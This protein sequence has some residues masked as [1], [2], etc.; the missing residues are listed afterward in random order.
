[1]D[2]LTFLFAVLFTVLMF[3]LVH[4]FIGL[5]LSGVP[6]AANLPEFGEA[7]SIE[8]KTSSSGQAED[9]DGQQPRE[10]FPTKQTAET[11][12]YTGRSLPFS[13]MGARNDRSASQVKVFTDFSSDHDKT[14]VKE[15]S[16]KNQG[17]EGYPIRESVVPFPAR[18]LASLQQSDPK[19]QRDPSHGPVADHPAPDGEKTL[20]EEKHID[21][22][23]T[24][25]GTPPSSVDGNQ[26][27][28][29]LAD[30]GISSN[31][32][33]R[34]SVISGEAM[35]GRGKLACEVSSLGARTDTELS[36]PIHEGEIRNG[37]HEQNLMGARKDRSAS[38]VKV[39]T[40]FSS[41]HDK[42]S[43]KEISG[44]NQGT[45]GYPIK[46]SVV[47]F[48]AR[49]LASLQQS[50]PKIQRDP[51]HGP[52]ADH[53][54]PD[55][56]KTLDE[57]KHIDVHPTRHGTPPSSVDGNQGP[58]SLA[59]SGISS[60][61]SVR[62][63]VISGEAM[64]GR[65]KLTTIQPVLPRQR[66]EFI[67]DSFDPFSFTVGRN[68][69]IV[70]TPYAEII[71][72]CDA[73]DE[74]IEITVRPDYY[75]L[76]EKLI[77]DS[78][79]YVSPEIFF[80]SKDEMMFKNEVTINLE[81]MYSAIDPDDPL[82]LN[83]E[84]IDDG[85]VE[86]YSKLEHGQGT[87]AEFKVKTFCGY[88]IYALKSEFPKAK[89]HFYSIICLRQPPIE[90][91]KHH[92]I[93]WYIFDRCEIELRSKS[94]S[95]KD[96]GFHALGLSESF[97]VKYG[98]N[99]RLRFQSNRNVQIASRK[100][101]IMPFWGD[102]FSKD[103]RFT[104]DANKIDLSG[105][106]A[107][108][109]DEQPVIKYTITEIDP[110]SNEETLIV[111]NG[112]LP[113]D[114]LVPAQ[115]TE[116]VMKGDSS[117][118][119]QSTTYVGD[120]RME[121]SAKKLPHSIRMA[122]NPNEREASDAF[123]SY[124]VQARRNGRYPIGGAMG[125]HNQDNQ[126]PSS[127]STDSSDEDLREQNLDFQPEIF[128]F[129]SPDESRSSSSRRYFNR[130]MVGQR[131]QSETGQD[132]GRK[133][134]GLASNYRSMPS[135][136]IRRSCSLTLDNYRFLPSIQEQHH[137]EDSQSYSLTSRVRSSSADGAHHRTHGRYLDGCRSREADDHKN[138]DEH[139]PRNQQELPIN[140]DSE[141]EQQILEICA[142]RIS[143]QKEKQD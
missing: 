94:A 98:Q 42:T 39:S 64:E 81:V 117:V 18:L 84:R 66:D 23:P 37:E 102:P 138:N 48:P 71:F 75:R 35:E 130:P 80:E 25:H 34:S 17:T 20:D 116:I 41:D 33:V 129:P 22:H 72:P 57:E 95:I 7:K 52:V 93:H 139:W 106:E 91:P 27:P 128:I 104:I 44:K 137:R 107:D 86:N 2:V 49:L 60:N 124:D 55:G 134:C 54:A 6:V 12:I 45:E 73:V 118:A 88:C 90:T 143:G 105:S 135:H 113:F 142:Q 65:E 126:Q 16:G 125:G 99:V 29:S 78:R 24:R 14:S 61:L 119:F 62:S 68:G 11:K 133:A 4:R 82:I 46:E 47:P 101:E 108:E 76:R 74:K 31:L 59:D 15:I 19:I 100:V 141:D 53:P 85:V 63:S 110:A 26:G 67:D 109:E 97:T 10:R 89:R 127:I 51:S 111:L 96:L 5:N 87:K 56:E 70:K 79:I 120:S 77:D 122:Q 13:T 69:C 123:Q 8:H 1:M 114:W 58:P 30:S 50:D 112:S 36:V 115:K 92:Y 9:K 3:I 136:P 43:V 28:P 121:I 132:H 140:Q 40:D 131:Y 21:V 32:S 83:V 38:Q 103:E